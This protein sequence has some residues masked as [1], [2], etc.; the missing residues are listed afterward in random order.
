MTAAWLRFA[1]LTLNSLLDVGCCLSS[2]VCRLVSATFC[3]NLSTFKV[4]RSSCKNFAIRHC[5]VRI[6]FRI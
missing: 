1:Q 5:P 3:N 4:A 6:K 2:V